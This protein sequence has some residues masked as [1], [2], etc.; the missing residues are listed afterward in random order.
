M[1]NSFRLNTDFTSTLLDYLL[2]YGQTESNTVFI[3]LCCSLKFAES[4]EKLRDVFLG[5]TGSRIF[6]M[7]DQVLI[8][9]IVASFDINRALS[10]KLEGILD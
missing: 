6:H 3:Q 8:L 7:H 1:S 5:D 4:I 10:G 9:S 2:H